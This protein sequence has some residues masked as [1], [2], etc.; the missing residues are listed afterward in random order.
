MAIYPDKKNG[1]LTGRFRVELQRGKDR[2]RK[3]HDSFQE[4]QADEERVQ[5]L[6]ATGGDIHAP[7]VSPAAPEG[8]TLRRAVK[9]AQSIL[10]KDMPSA[11][12][13]WA[14]IRDF[15][16]F[17]GEDTLLDDIGTQHIR[18]F[19]D[20]VASLGRS[21]ATVNRY[22]AHVRKFMIWHLEEGNRT[23]PITKQTLKFDINRETAGRLRWLSYAEEETIVSLVPAN[24]GKLI[25]V[26][27]A[28]GCR[29]DEL[30]TAKLDQIDGNLLHLWVTKNDAYRAVPMSPETTAMLRELIETRTMPSR[31]VL[32]RSWE[33]ARIKMGLQ[34]DHEFVFHSCRHTCATR[35]VDAGVDVLKIQKWL[36]HKR[37]ETTQ[38]YAHVT[39]AGLVEALALVGERKAQVTQKASNSGSP[40]PPPHAPHGG[41]MMQIDLAA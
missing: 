30:I 10:W 21:K 26:A 22:V 1:E 11:P 32:R 20:H 27:I 18:D 31:R 29:R 4:A 41:E 12:T 34:D 28:T 9:L 6:W 7:V 16:E 40:T 3:R 2:Y 5:V 19:R 38:R 35:M 15:L 25:R 23:V 13:S 33:R 14:H 17:T 24:V 36:G 37:I 39:G 8:M